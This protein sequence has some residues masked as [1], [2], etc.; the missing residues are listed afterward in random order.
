M[1]LTTTQYH[2]EPVRVRPT[3]LD[4]KRTLRRVAISFGDVVSSISVTLTVEEA[5]AM[6]K[7]IDAALES[8][9]NGGAK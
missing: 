5:I 9:T 1:M 7:G 4:E 8:F 2:V 6:S 3:F